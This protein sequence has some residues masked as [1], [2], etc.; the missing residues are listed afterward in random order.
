MEL[1]VSLTSCNNMMS[2]EGKLLG[3]HNCVCLTVVYN[4]ETAIEKFQNKPLAYV[5]FVQQTGD[6]LSF[7]RQVTIVKTV[8]LLILDRR[9][10]SCVIGVVFICVICVTLCFV[11]LLY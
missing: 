3:R 4:F 7:L 2:R 10:V 8:Y 1:L 5:L 11:L 6:A 9:G